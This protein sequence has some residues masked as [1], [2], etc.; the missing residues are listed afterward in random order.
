MLFKHFGNVITANGTAPQY[1]YPYSSYIGTFF[2]VLP[3]YK[4]NGEKVLLILVLFLLGF[5]A[6]PGSADIGIT[7]AYAAILNR[8]LPDYF[9]AGCLAKTVLWELRLPCIML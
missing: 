1:G 7:E 3:L 6:I 5:S 2:R 4:S 8:L 9:D